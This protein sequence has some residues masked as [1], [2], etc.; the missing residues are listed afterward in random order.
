MKKTLI[1][2]LL[3]VTV[4]LNAQN[5]QLLTNGNLNFATFELSKTYKHGAL[6]YFSDMKMDK[7]GFREVYSEISGY[8]NI[9]KTLSV[10]AQYNA[11]I[12]KEF[13]IYP[14]YLCG[15]SNAFTFGDH[16]TLSVDVTYRHQNYLYIPSEEKTNGYQITPSFVLDYKKFQA[17]G[18]CDFW[19]S[20]YYILEPQAWYKLFKTLWIGAEWRMSNYSDVLD[21]DMNGYYMGSYANYIMGGIKWNI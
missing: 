3:S 15:L 19:N 18:Y 13:L 8:V 11:G 1:L 2:I 10:T 6:Y 4:S 5:I 20:K 12:N 7:D 21:Y 14:V 9:Y 16:F 17:S